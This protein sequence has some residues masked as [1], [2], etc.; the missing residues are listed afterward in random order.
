[1]RGHLVVALCAIGAAG[2]LPSMQLEPRF[3]VRATPWEMPEV[4]GFW[5][6][7]ET[8]VGPY[9]VRDV[10][11]DHRAARD[12]GGFEIRLV[13]VHPEGREDAVRCTGTGVPRR[14]D[15]MSCELRGALGVR[16]MTSV[17]SHPSTLEGEVRYVVR[18]AEGP[19]ASA[20][21][22]VVLRPRPTDARGGYYVAHG[23]ELLAA[24]DL[25]VIGVP[26]AHADPDLDPYAEHEVASILATL[27]IAE[28]I[29]L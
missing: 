22:Y 13:V 18:D 4:Y 23:A 17:P 14:G 10:R 5:P 3:A 26:R 9:V 12:G 19:D 24:I 21:R 29:A 2:C 11:I 1:M 8:R 28:G 6:P 27:F 16:M 7:G 15:G 25:T 20:D